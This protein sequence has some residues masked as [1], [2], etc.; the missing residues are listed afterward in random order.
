MHRDA[1]SEPVASVCGLHRRQQGA[2][3][4]QEQH[5]RH[6]ADGRESG[7]GS[8]LTVRNRRVTSRRRLIN[9]GSTRPSGQPGRRFGHPFTR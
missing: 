3:D 1:P 2:G 4:E 9:T 8:F 7:R 5:G 6:F